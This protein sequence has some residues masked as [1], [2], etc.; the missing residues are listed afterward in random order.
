MTMAIFRRHPAPI[1]TVIPAPRLGALLAPVDERVSQI[2]AA[3]PWT[4]VTVDPHFVLGDC[5]WCTPTI[6]EPSSVRVYGDPVHDERVHEPLLMVEVCIRCA[7]DPQA[8]PIRR[9]AEQSKTSADIRV[10][11]SA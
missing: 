5:R 7:L 6:P 4:H 8:S 11:V 1:P 3:F 9:A 10:E 2:E